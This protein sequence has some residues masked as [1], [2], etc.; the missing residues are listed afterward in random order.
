MLQTAALD[1]LKRCSTGTSPHLT[2]I[3]TQDIF[4]GDSLSFLVQIQQGFAQGGVKQFTEKG[5]LSSTYHI[6]NGKKSGTEIVYYSPT[7]ATGNLTKLSIDWDEG[8]IH[9]SVKTWY[10]D[11]QMQSQREFC[12]NKKMGPSLSWYRN[13]SLMLVEEYDQ[14]KLV[15]GQ[16]YKKNALDSVSSVI[17]GTGV[18]QL[19]DENGVFLRKISYIKGE[20]TD[21]E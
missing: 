2:T 14:D 6:K 4:E 17:N 15:K 10:K 11:G 3:A 9:G 20:A 5:N 8:R 21:P 1:I 7:E 13:G 18:A 16:Y 19:Y 12:R